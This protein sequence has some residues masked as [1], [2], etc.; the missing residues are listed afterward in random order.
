MIIDD[1]SI[2]LLSNNRRLFSDSIRESYSLHPKTKNQTQNVTTIFKNYHKWLAKRRSI[3]NIL[4]NK[5]EISILFV[6]GCIYDT[7]PEVF[8]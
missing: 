8:C 7:I 2:C 6:L 4:L 1:F 3:C 5:F